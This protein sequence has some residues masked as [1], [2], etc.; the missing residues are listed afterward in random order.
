VSEV[1]QARHQLILLGRRKGTWGV[2]VPHRWKPYQVID[3]STKQPFTEVSARE[4]ILVLLESGHPITEVELREPPG[5]VGYVLQVALEPAT[6]TIYIKLQLG[7]G[8]ILCRSFH[9]TDPR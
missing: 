2:L 4:L 8:A 6:P 9:Y 5:R 3:P 1:E 7:S